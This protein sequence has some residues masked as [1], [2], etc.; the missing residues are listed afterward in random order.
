MLLRP[1]MQGPFVQLVEKDTPNRSSTGGQ[2]RSSLAV[3]R[4][5]AGRVQYG[6]NPG[7]MS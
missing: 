6:P 2:S 7:N 5:C 4:S 3:L 1:E